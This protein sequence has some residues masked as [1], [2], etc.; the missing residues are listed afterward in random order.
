MFLLIAARFFGPDETR[1]HIERRLLGHLRKF[2]AAMLVSL[3]NGPDAE[4]AGLDIPIGERITRTITRRL[5]R[6]R[7]ETA[8]DR[9]PARAKRRCAQ[10]AAER[11]TRAINASALS[12]RSE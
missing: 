9:A 5:L 3:K 8:A 1:G 4:W 6:E 11:F 7:C 10:V 2:R 12:L